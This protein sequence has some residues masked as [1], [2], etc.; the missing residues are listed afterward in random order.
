MRKLTIC[1]TL[2]FCLLSLG[3]SAQDPTA[4]IVHQTNG[5]QQSTSLVTI[6][7]ITFEA[8]NLVLTTSEGVFRLPMGD[9]DYVTFGEGGSVETDVENVDANAV[10]IFQSG[11]QLLIES[12][13]VINALYLVDI[14]GKLIENQRLPSASEANVT[15]PQAGAYVLFLDTN[16]GYIARKVINY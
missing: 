6:S 8:D 15:L 10:R 1:L 9:I 13:Y 16:H 3:L 7:H 12:E 2:L 11:N 4:M 14:T 5:V